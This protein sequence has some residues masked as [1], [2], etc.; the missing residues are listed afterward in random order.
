MKWP[1]HHVNV[2]RNQKVILVWNSRRCEF[3]HVNTPLVKCTLR[4]CHVQS[5]K[6]IKYN[7]ASTD[8]FSRDL[9]T[10][11]NP[12]KG[13]EEF[14]TL[15]K[16]QSI[17]SCENTFFVLICTGV[18]FY[19]LNPCLTSKLETTLVQPFFTLFAIFLMLLMAYGFEHTIVT[20]INKNC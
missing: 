15:K 7:H 14:L 1:S 17:F 16:T 20:P 13:S 11:W 9:Y 8:P 18:F 6:K 10:I 12:C 19:V 4:M 5:T 2:I 3:S